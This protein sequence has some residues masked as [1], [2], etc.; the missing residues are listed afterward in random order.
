M[1]FNKLYKVLCCL[2]DNIIICSH[3][4]T[5]MKI[6]E[7]NGNI[8]SKIELD[9][10]PIHKLFSFSKLYTRFFR[11]EVFSVCLHEDI[12]F[13]SFKNTIYEIHL[14]SFTLL[15]TYSN[16]V[17]S[18]PLN[19]TSVKDIDGFDNGVYFGDYYFNKEQEESGIYRIANSTLEK[20]YTFP[21]GV[22]D[23]THNIICDSKRSCLYIMTGDFGD[24]AGIW[25]SSNNFQ[26]VE[27][28]LRGDQMYRA[29][30][31][32]IANDHLVYFTDSQFTAN[33]MIKLDL[34]YIHST[35][36]EKVAQ[37]NGPCI[38]GTYVNGKYL[39]STS[40]EPEI[41]K[42]TFFNIWSNK[43]GFGIYHNE[44]KIYSID[45]DNLDIK[46]IHSFHK[47]IHSMTLF[48]FGNGFF[49]LNH[50]K[51]NDTYVYTIAVKNHDL[52]TT[53]ISVNA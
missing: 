17:G 22:I 34:N 14:A 31:G 47:D 27:S 51:S 15:K 26:N 32:F 2:D 4:S 36:I 24:A 8:L 5:L 33:Y 38:Y 7:T 30:Y 9:I 23:H 12:I 16:F 49:P 25:K 40:C 28:I 21:N 50:R 43:P 46:Q 45:P 20:V 18:R 29:C 42:Y 1:N 37:I 13:V 10:S 53:K 44:V 11:N 48:Q 52:S 41:D 6:D 3:Q 35:S 39:I 19:M